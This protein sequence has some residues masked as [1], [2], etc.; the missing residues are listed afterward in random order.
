MGNDLET[1]EILYLTSFCTNSKERFLF[2][3]VL[4]IIQFF[5]IAIPINFKHCIKSIFTSKMLYIYKLSS[6]I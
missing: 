3:K 5:N 2:I 1:S 6:C 4:I